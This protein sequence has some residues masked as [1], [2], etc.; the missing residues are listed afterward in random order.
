ML[1]AVWRWFSRTL[2][3]ATFR[4]V[5]CV[6]PFRCTLTFRALAHGVGTPQWASVHLH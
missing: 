3:V 4:G 1:L 2:V 6:G 5:E